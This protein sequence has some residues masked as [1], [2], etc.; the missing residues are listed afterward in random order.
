[1][2]TYKMF[3]DGSIGCTEQQPSTNIKDVAKFWQSHGVDTNEDLTD[4]ITGV[5]SLSDMPTKFVIWYGEF[6]L[7]VDAVN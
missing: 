2:Y 3:D 5:V 1:M 6:G 4:G 7:G